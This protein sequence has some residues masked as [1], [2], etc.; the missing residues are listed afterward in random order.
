MTEND[1]PDKQEPPRDHN[2]Q[3]AEIVETPSPGELADALRGIFE[4]LGISEDDPRARIVISEV[5]TLIGYR[6]PIPPP[7]MLAEYD[8]ILPGLANRI[9]EAWEAQFQ[10]RKDLENSTTRASENRMDRSQRNALIVSLAGILMAGV[11]GI[12]GNWVAAAIIVAVAVGGPNVATIIA[13][14][15]RGPND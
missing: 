6:G 3:N 15:I 5:R 2:Q 8:K 12:W 4:Q 13:R 11:V 1:K 14:L 10:H 9:V 7:E